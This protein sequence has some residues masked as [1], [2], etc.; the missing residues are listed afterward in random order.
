MIKRLFLLWF[1]RFLPVVAVLTSAAL[2]A[3]F[4]GKVQSPDGKP[5]NGAT[6]YF[7]DL[8]GGAGASRAARALPTTRT[9]EDGAFHFPRGDSNNVEF[10]AAADGFGGS[11]GR[12]SGAAPTLIRLHPR[13]DL[14]VTLVDADKN[15]VM[16]LGVSVQE[17]VLPIQMP[18]GL[19]NNVWIPGKDQSPWS[20]T[21]DK[22]GVCVIR[23]LPQGARVMLRFDDERYAE[24]SFADLVALGA[25]AGTRARPIQLQL[26]ASI[27]GRVFYE[28]TNKPTAGVRVH[29]RASDNQ[30]DMV[31]GADGSYVFNRLRADQYDIC[32]NLDGE[33][34][35]SWTTEAGVR[36][37][38]AA[39]EARANVNFLLISGVVLSG[40]VLSADDSKPVAGVALGIF[41]PSHPRNGGMA[42][43]VATDA[44]GSFS[45]RVPPGGQNV[46]IISDSPANGFAKPLDDEKTVNIPAGG[47]ASVEFRLP[48]SKLFSVKGKVVDP[49]GKPVANAEVSVYYVQ[50][51]NTFNENGIATGADGTFQ[52]VP[53]AEVEEI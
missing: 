17:I 3:D 7:V 44:D 14:T 21:T 27:S 13:T 33:T 35:K 23:G 37:V 36:V 39:G 1:G 5:V 47:T 26:A 30:R 28:S 8:G 12:A 46:D 22:S 52:T 9:D 29:L 20:A 53:V 31:T 50:R 19:G 51:S 15:P 4:A 25:S 45:V 18:Q 41:G 40:K 11:S 34:Q 2:G 43:S 16:N 48:R 24:L 10:V 32:V 6:V 49:D 38:V 42:Q